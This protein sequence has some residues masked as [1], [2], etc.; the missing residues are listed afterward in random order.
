MKCFSIISGLLLW[1]TLSLTYFVEGN[2]V[3]AA[4][5][6]ILPAAAV[7]LLNYG[8]TMWTDSASE[9]MLHVCGFLTISVFSLPV[10]YAFGILVMS[11]YGDS[12]TTASADT[13]RFIVS[14]MLLSLIVVSPSSYIFFKKKAEAYYRDLYEQYRNE[15]AISILREKEEALLKKYL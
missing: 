3:L 11:V 1:V 5:V 15:R 9:E 4:L 14:L 10:G 13:A 6:G 8:L 2:T 7:S 12:I